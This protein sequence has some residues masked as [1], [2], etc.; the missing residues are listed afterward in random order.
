[1]VKA[2]PGDDGELRGHNGRHWRNVEKFVE[3]PSF[4]ELNGGLKE[5][6]PEANLLIVCSAIKA[7]TDPWQRKKCCTTCSS[8]NGSVAEEETSCRLIFN[9]NSGK[10][11]VRQIA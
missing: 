1:L 2:D 5:I 10:D 6:D 4:E 11:F 8:A 3:H 7:H 9:A